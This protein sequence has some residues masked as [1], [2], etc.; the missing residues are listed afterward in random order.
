LEQNCE[1]DCAGKLREEEDAARIRWYNYDGKFD[2]ASS[3][4]EDHWEVFQSNS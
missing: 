2:V 1:Q 4:M 3:N